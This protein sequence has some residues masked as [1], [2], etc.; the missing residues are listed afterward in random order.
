MPNPAPSKQVQAV[1]DNMPP[2]MRKGAIA[3]R[4]LIYDTAAQLGQNPPQESLKWGQPSYVSTQGTP[5]RIAASKHGAFGLF[6]HC[7]STVISEFAQIF[8]ND[9]AIQGN[10]E[11]SFANVADI[12]PDKLKQLI[13]H[14]LTY[15]T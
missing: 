9:F 8:G 12:Q 6:A 10:R 15:R 13:V 14:A 7:Q 2:Q 1:L 5:L 4:H 3:L 11:V